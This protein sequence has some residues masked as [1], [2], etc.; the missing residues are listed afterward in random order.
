MSPSLFCSVFVNR[1]PSFGF[2]NLT[3]SNHQVRTGANRSGR[4][5]NGQLRRRR[6]L[7]KSGFADYRERA[8]EQRTAWNSRIFTK[9]SGLLVPINRQG[10]QEHG[11]DP[12]D[13]IFRAILFFFFSHRGSTAYLKLWFKCCFDF[14]TVKRY[15]FEAVLVAPV[16]L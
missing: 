8:R 10:N 16:R 9:L 1:P 7:E 14:S 15:G 3:K 4:R 12:E 6:G 13:D 11:N 2:C 5:K